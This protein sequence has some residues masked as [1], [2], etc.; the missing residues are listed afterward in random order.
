MSSLTVDI[1]TSAHRR[2]PRVRVLDTMSL[3]VCTG[4]VT[5]LVG[6][7]GCGKSMVAAALCGLL[8]PGC[9]VTGSVRIDQTTL[10]HDDPAWDRL[11]GRVVGLVPQSSS[12]SFT[13]V[14]TVR[15]QLREVV[16]VLDGPGSFEQLC[17]LVRLP[18]G[19]L[20]LY[21]H[22]LSGGMAQRAAIAAAIA[23]NPAVVV[24]DEPTSALD[25]ELA[26]TVWELLARLARRGTAVLAITHDLDSLRRAGIDPAV[27]VMRHGRLLNQT[28]AGHFLADP[29]AAPS[30]TPDTEEC[31]D[32]VY[33]RAF[34]S[35]V[36]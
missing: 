32:E 10:T 27:A 11:R 21:P 30:P 9:T 28:R 6:E 20:D 24:A 17:D 34:F 5:V 25:P 19:A 36:H 22:E 26:H 1:A 3:A 15:S 18:R 7:S 16:S 2:S 14:R 4:E 8:P 29:P 33:L 13:P 23:G 12:T 35:E 31:D